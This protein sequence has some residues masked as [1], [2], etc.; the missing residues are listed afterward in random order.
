ML[1]K[2][3]TYGGLLSIAFL[4]LKLLEGLAFSNSLNFNF[5][6]S[7]IAFLF[8]GLGIWLSRNWKSK[9]F[10]IT[11]NSIHPNLK[12]QSILS[13]REQE[14]LQ[15]MANGM[16]NKEIAK[17]LFLSENTIKTHASNLYFKLDVKRRTQAIQRAREMALI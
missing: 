11:K 1:K 15:A 8:F 7:L 13:S 3:L 16:S 17:H 5:I 9:E 14:V 12:E 4:L 2:G 6:V 10:E